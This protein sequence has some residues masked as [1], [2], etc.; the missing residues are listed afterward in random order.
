MICKVSMS[1]KVA[2]INSLR[3]ILWQ[4]YAIIQ[5]EPNKSSILSGMIQYT[6]A[7]EF[8]Q[9]HQF[10]TKLWQGK[11]D[12]KENAPFHFDEC[13]KLTIFVYAKWN[14]FLQ[15]HPKSGNR[16][17]N[18]PFSEGL[19]LR[20]SKK[21]SNCADKATNIDLTP[22][23]MYFYLFYLLPILRGWS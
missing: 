16:K 18:V 13:P 15:G 20:G 17:N 4:R 11:T 19:C 21:S 3:K 22:W 2:M 9:L 7:P 5:N 23:G 12:M 10:H 8:W 1:L 6:K 14:L